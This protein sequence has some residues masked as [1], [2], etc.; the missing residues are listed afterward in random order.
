VPQTVFLSFV[1][2]GFLASVG[3]LIGLL[4]VSAISSYLGKGMEFTAV[5]AIVTPRAGNPR[6][7][8]SRQSSVGK[9]F[10]DLPGGHRR[11]CI[12]DFGKHGENVFHAVADVHDHHRSDTDLAEVLL[13]SKILICR[14]D[15]G[16]TPIDGGTKK[17]AIAQTFETLASD[18]R[19]FE[20]RNVRQNLLGD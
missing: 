14:E 6:G 4:Q 12:L 5:A 3:G 9:Y 8:N 16:E 11:N 17:N 1:A 10:D 20:L 13:K 7:R 18:D 19:R 15:D 2:S